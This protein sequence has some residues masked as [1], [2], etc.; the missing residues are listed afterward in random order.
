MHISICENPKSMMKEII[1]L[2][3][4]M[5][6][7]PLWA[8]GYHQSRWSYHPSSEVL[9][10]GR[11]LRE[12]NIPCDAIY[13]DIDYMDG[14]RCFTWDEENFG[15]LPKLV[16][17]L[18]KL[19][20]KVVPMIDPGI[21]VDE[22]YS[23]YSEGKKENFFLQLEGQEYQD[24]VWP[25][26][27]A[28]P[29]FFREDVREWWQN[30]YQEMVNFGVDGFFNDMNEVS[31]FN[32]R[33]TMPDNVIHEIE[34]QK[35]E[36]YKVH[37]LYSQM[38]AK[39]SYEGLR[40]LYSPNRVF[41]L[42]RSGYIGSQKYGFIWTGDNK[43]DWD[44]LKQSISKL[45]NSGLSGHFANGADV[46]GFRENPDPELFTRWIQLSTFYPYC[47]NHTSIMSKNQE[48]WLFGSEIESICR[49]FISLRYKLLPYL[50]TWFWYAARVGVPLIRPLWMEYPDDHRCYEKKWLDTQFFFGPQILVAP[51]LEPNENGREIYLPTGVWYDYF[52]QQK[53]EGNQ[54]LTL[55]VALDEMVILVKE[56]TILPVYNDIGINVEETIKSEITYQTFGEPKI[57]YLYKDDG[58]STNYLDGD[59]DLFKITR[60]LTLESIDQI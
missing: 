35:I 10:I 32:L 27:C 21:K 45:I 59:F 16:E 25:G 3:G 44:H 17:E 39:A 30:K 9:R 38:M 41:L 36:H 53:F 4:Q 57:G 15:S 46:G 49:T 31:V 55:S 11:L 5:E 54:I 58:T 52:T 42:I 28:F 6:L 48:P 2:L 43:S 24:K 34:G 50:Y 26:L 20:F 51:I 7:P 40:N 1:K 29:D 18:H 23:I 14:Y 56:G 8:L 60:D 33:G 37:N 19:D 47:R 13:L 12:K 22:S